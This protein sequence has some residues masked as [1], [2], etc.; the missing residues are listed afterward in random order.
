MKLSDL[1]ITKKFV[2]IAFYWNLPSKHYFFK[3]SNNKN[4]L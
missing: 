1:E 3:A 2:I 4:T